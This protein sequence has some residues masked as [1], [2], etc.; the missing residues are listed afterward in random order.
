MILKGISGGEMSLATTTDFCLIFWR[1]SNI[2]A[3]NVD[4]FEFFSKPHLCQNPE[5]VELTT[6]VPLHPNAL[7]EGDLTS[8]LIYTGLSQVVNVHWELLYIN[9]ERD[10]M[11]TLWESNVL[12]FEGSL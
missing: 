4:R 7:A 10:H 6:S 1:L 8:L 12:A 5:C 11:L 9:T 3:L 2:S